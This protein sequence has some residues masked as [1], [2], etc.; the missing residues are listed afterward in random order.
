MPR[1]EITKTGCERTYDD[2]GNQ[3]H[4]KYPS[5]IEV[6]FEYDSVGNMIHSKDSTGYERW[7]EYHEKERI[8]HIKDSYGY[9]AWW[10]SNGKRISKKEFDQLLQ[11]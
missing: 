4:V 8:A 10:N 7:F 11:E 6:W 1:T 5:S 2:N 3:I 9:E